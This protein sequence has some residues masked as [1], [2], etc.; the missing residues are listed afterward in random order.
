MKI[1][2][3]W[4]L[5]LAFSA[6]VLLATL[7][8]Y[9]SVATRRADINFAVTFIPAAILLVALAPLAMTKIVVH[10]W[11][12]PIVATW[13]S[14]AIVAVHFTGRWLTGFG[15]HCDRVVLVVSIAAFCLLNGFWLTIG[16]RSRHRWMNFCR[17]KLS[18]SIQAA[19]I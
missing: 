19:A 1:R 2:F 13:A 5:A 18:R 3:R 15:N 6:W 14:S 12:V 17:R 10:R 9:A 8:L 16:S 11:A 4:I 7:F